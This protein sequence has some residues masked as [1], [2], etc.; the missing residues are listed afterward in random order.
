[1]LVH[2]FF[3]FVFCDYQTRNKSEYKHY[4]SLWLHLQSLFS[5]KP[6]LSVKLS[7]HLKLFLQAKHV[8]KLILC[9]FV[10]V[11]GW[12]SLNLVLNP[13]NQFSVLFLFSISILSILLDNRWFMKQKLVLNQVHFPE[14]HF[15]DISLHFIRIT[16]FSF[17]KNLTV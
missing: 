10:P 4:P 12:F 13:V 15:V 9:V 7:Y 6:T 17:E 8:V 1:M 14:Q 16:F 2:F 3:V 11:T 5:L